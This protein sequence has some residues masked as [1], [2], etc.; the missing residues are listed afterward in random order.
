MSIIA[1]VRGAFG[2]RSAVHPNEEIRRR[3]RARGDFGRK[4]RMVCHTARFSTESQAS[5]FKTFV[6]FRGYEVIEASHANLVC[7]ERISKIV[8]K[9]F[10][11]ETDFLRQEI[12]D[13]RGDYEGFGSASLR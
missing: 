1:K 10:D 9:Q 8:G 2:I 11:A 12:D 4:P 13:L 3:H 7:F 6:T 5:A